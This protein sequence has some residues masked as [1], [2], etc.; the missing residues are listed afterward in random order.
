MESRCQ[1]FSTETTQLR[2]EVD[3]LQQELKK[4]QQQKTHAESKLEAA[5]QRESNLSNCAAECDRL[6]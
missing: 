4:W 6:K 3:R 1:T 5:L 2:G